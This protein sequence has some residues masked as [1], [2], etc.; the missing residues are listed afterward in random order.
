MFTAKRAKIGDLLEIPTAKGLAY[1][2]YTH[3]HE[4]YGP[5][6]R[7]FH[8]LHSS[9][10]EDLNLVPQQKVLFSTFCHVPSAINQGFMSIVKSLPLGEV[11][12]GFPVFRSGLV[13]PNRRVNKWWFWDGE[14]SWPVGKISESQKSMPLKEI[15]TASMLVYRIEHG[16]T[17][18]KDI[19]AN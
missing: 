18:E 15:V 1:A 11:L 8:G 5:L 7:V 10:P 9:Q 19:R 12:E 14:K 16:W 4:K 13:E 2:Q 6:L 17:P 3:K